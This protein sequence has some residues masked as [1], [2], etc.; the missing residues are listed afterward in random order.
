[1]QTT[2]ETIFHPQNYAASEHS[3]VMMAY[4]LLKLVIIAL[5]T[6]HVAHMKCSKGERNIHVSICDVIQPFSEHERQT[7]KLTACSK[8]KPVVVWWKRIQ[9]SAENQNMYKARTFT[10]SPFPSPVL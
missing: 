7:A 9:I 6:K 5:E 8:T 1:M 3:L 2:L 10:Q 4:G